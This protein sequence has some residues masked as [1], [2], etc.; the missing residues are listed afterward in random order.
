MR[1][2]GVIGGQTSMVQSINRFKMGFMSNRGELVRSGALFKLR[3]S[4]WCSRFSSR[5]APGD[6]YDD[7]SFLGCQVYDES[8]RPTQSSFLNSR[9]N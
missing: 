7:S 9:N 6:V 4:I 2:S 1:V 5:H 3:F 8:E